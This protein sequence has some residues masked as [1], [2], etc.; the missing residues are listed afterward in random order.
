MAVRAPDLVTSMAMAWESAMALA[1][2]MTRAHRSSCRRA[3]MA[4]RA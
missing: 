2:S 4:Q 3:T 1:L